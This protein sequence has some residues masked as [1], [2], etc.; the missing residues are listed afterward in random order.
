MSIPGS[1]L[2]VCWELRGGEP[3]GPS[4]CG[5]TRQNR[6]SCLKKGKSQRSKYKTEFLENTED[7]R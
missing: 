6:S 2:V 5:R 4:G 1:E 3:G 7:Q